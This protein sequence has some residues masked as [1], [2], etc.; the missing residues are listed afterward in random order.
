MQ[1]KSLSNRIFVHVTSTDKTVSNYLKVIDKVSL[2][3]LW[4]AKA[5]AYLD[6]YF[7][8]LY[9]S[10][11]EKDEIVRGKIIHDIE[12]HFMTSVSYYLRCFLDQTGSRLVINDVTKD[13]KLREYFH[14]IMN[15]R[16]G[17]F[18]HWD[19]VRSN[20]KVAYSF[21]VLDDKS[22]A[23]GLELQMSY[24]DKIGPGEGVLLNEL[25]TVTSE[26]I[27]NK[28]NKT[29]EKLRAIFQNDEARSKTSLL[30]DAGESIFKK[31]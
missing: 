20:M 15:L 3:D 21:D 5:K 28:R 11:N 27:I 29:L 14:H 22:A 8:L 4:V 26:H 1:N 2:L 9:S 17:E 12:S 19:G 18:V 30:N 7:Q 16:N 31:A 25:Y 6:S 10:D 13:V 24:S 23:F